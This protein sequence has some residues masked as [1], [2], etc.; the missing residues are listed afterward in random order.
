MSYISLFLRKLVTRRAANRCEYCQLSQKGQE[1]TFHVDH[2]VPL[3]AGG[4]TMA[5][6]LALA[7]VSCSLKKGAREFVIDA[8]TNRKV[9][10]FHPRKDIWRDHFEWQGVIVTAKTPTGI[11][12]LELLDL[13]RKLILAI[14][15]EEI[16]L[17]RHP[18]NK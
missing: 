12:T 1:A 14:R 11:A 18:F 5:E 4:K 3:A 17:K 8:E 15:E 9:K 6:N 7:Y 2:I 13:N 16:L 10:L